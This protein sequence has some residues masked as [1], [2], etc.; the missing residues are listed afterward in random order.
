MYQQLKRLVAEDIRV[1]SLRPGDAQI[2]EHGLCERFGVSRTVVRQALAQLE[3]EDAIE[4]VKGMFV[5]KRK[6]AEVLVHTLNGLYE[7]VEARGG[8]VRS[9]VRRQEL[10]QADSMVAGAL[11]IAER[12]R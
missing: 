12:G 1:R 6:T 7:D 8:D 4:R 3:H 9:V 5:D 10:T 11:E 2:G